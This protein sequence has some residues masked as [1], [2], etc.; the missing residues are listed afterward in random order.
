[1]SAQ[2]LRSAADGRLVAFV[3]AGVS[4]IAPTCLPSWWGMN[5]RVVVALRDRVTGLVG[6]DR[7]RALAEAITARQEANRFPPEYQA[8]VIVHRLRESYFPVLQ[9]LDSQTPNDVH[10]AIAALAK[11]RRLTAVVTTNFD[12]ALEAAFRQL[13][14]EAEVWSNPAQFGPLADRL[15]DAGATACPIIKLHG[16]VEEP[17]TLVDT[18]SQRKRGFAPDVARSV[19]QLLR[20]AHWLFLGYSGADLMADENYLFLKPDAAEAQGF[21][22]LLRTSEQPVPALEATRAVYGNRAEIVHGELPGWLAGFAKPLLTDSPPAALAL[23]EAAI[24]EARRAGEKRVADHTAAWVASE[25]FDSAVLVFADL[26]EAVGEPQAGFDIVRQLYETT[27]GDERGSPHFGIVVNALANDYAQSSRYDEA[28]ALFQ[29]ALGIYDPVKDREQHLGALN[30]LALVYSNQGRTSDALEIFERL[31][32]F[33]NERGDNASRGVALHNVAMTQHRLGEDHEA[34]RLYQEEVRIVRALGDEPARAI[35]LNNL[36][37]LEVSR[38]RFDRAVEYLNEAAMVRDRIG[39]DLGA[40]NTRANLANAHQLAG[41]ADLAG[42]LYAQSLDTF[43]RFGDRA[44][45][46]RTLG[47]IAQLK[48]STGKRAEALALLNQAIAEATAIGADPVRAQ[49]MQVLGE[50]QLKEGRND[51][52]A[53]TFQELVDLTVKMRDAIHERNAQ[54]G[55]GM[56]LKALDR[57]EPAIATLRRA[58]ALTEQHRF[59]LPEWPLE[60]LAD[61][62]NR[63]G[64]AR[65]QSGDLDGA[66]DEFAEAL[67]IWR[68][69]N[70]AFNEGQTLI[71]IGNTQVIAKR[72]AEAAATFQRAETTLLLG[73]DRESADRVAITAGELEV[74]LDRPD[75]ASTIFRR[76]VNRTADYQER[77]DRMNRIGALANK[78]LEHGAIGRALHILRDCA[79]WNRQDGFPPDAAACLINIGSILRA[80]GDGEGARRSFEQALELLRSEPQHPLF[81]QAQALLE[82][83][84]PVV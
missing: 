65:Q 7:A 58:R 57:F 12:R 23:D 13:G 84:G 26:L 17:S 9:S 3:G 41:E 77:A 44:T 11:A 5:Q 72:Y 16:S 15:H 6:A 81:A 30:N 32:T 67:D 31:L 70:S 33:A 40:A 47:N 69:R 20:S 29:E 28:V 61:A 64:L 25:R 27:R 60:H 75:E 62:L 74:W 10:L 4:S 18:L 19:R 66:M 51:E 53:R 49:T 82:A 43:R 36:G 52:S 2:A 80:T 55:L 54:M 38:R 37:E 50:I 71:N 83:A 22:W 76:V 63:D 45:A 8:E 78:Q 1:M 24:A 21:T 79:E 35:A 73:N 34:E 68:Q 56:S 39:D 14:M 59:P 48:E 42:Q 46:A